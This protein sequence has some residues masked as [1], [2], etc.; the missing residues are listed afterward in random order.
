[1]QTYVLAYVLLATC[2]L[3]ITCW[4]SVLTHVLN[5]VTVR[6]LA[7]IL[8]SLACCAYSRISLFLK[9]TKYVST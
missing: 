6:V 8:S 1:M 9:L 7:P 3:R 4:L 5:Y 2:H